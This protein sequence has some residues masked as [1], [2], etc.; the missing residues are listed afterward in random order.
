[1]DKVSTKELIKKIKADKG[2]VFEVSLCLVFLRATHTISWG[3]KKIYDTG[4]DSQEIKWKE[5]EF[6]E[7]YSES[8]WLIEQII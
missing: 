2:K 5:S 1:M 3:G 8:V 4:I 6:I 7:E